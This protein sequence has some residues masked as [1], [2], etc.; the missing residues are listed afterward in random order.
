MRSRKTIEVVV[1]AATCSVAACKSSNQQSAQAPVRPIT[2][3]G[4][5]LTPAAQAK[6]DSGRPTYTAADVSFMKGM[7][8]HH[9]QA[10]TMVAL[11]PTHGARADVRVLAERIGVSQR[12]EIALMRSWLVARNETVPDTSASHDHAGMSM[13]GMDMAGSMMPGML[14][15][16]QMTQLE[17]ATGPEFDRLFL[18]F[19]IQHHQGAIT[20]VSQLLAVPGAAGNVDIYRFAADVNVDQTTEINRMRVM[21]AAT[22]SGTPSR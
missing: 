8:G 5:V 6:A 17:R 20:M 2:A 7:I 10:L 3:E 11:A 15:P 21:L 9:A 1:L 13:P 14:S 4:S 16:A 22:P 12:D 18:T 19:M